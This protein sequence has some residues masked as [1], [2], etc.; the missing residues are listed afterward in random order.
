MA[1]DVTERIQSAVSNN[2]VMIFMKGT[3]SFPQ[4]GFSAAT[5]Q[6]FEQLGVPFETADV[7]SDP[8]LRDGI[9]RFTNWPTIP[10]VFVGGKFIGGC[11][12]VREMYES[13]DL[14]TLV[15]SVMK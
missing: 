6:V 2:K 15:D 12:I 1:Q 4:C 3:A 9:K 11:D 7:L 5:V 10:Q 8:E 14:K 13:G